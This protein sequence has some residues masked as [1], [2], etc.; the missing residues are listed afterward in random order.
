MFS[1]V[2][3]VFIIQIDSQL[4]PNPNGETAALLRVLLFKIDNTTF[5]NDV[6]PLP[7][8]TGPSRAMVQVQA[9]LFASLTVSLFSAFLA[10]LGKQWLNRYDSTDMRGSAIERSHNRQK[11]LDGIVAWYFN[12]VMES[13]PLMLQAAFLLLGCALSRY[14]WGIDIIIAVVVVGVTSSGV[15]FYL[16]IIIAGMTFESCPYQ[17]P[18]ARIL[19]HIFHHHL[20]ALRSGPS[21]IFAVVSSQCSEFIQTSRCCY[22]FRVWWSLMKPCWSWSNIGYTLAY[23]LLVLPFTL[24]IDGFR[25]GRAILRLLV[26]FGRTVYRGYNATFPPR[27]V[28]SQ[29][30]TSIMSDLRCISWILQTSLDRTIHLSA[31]KRLLSIPKFSHPDPTLV[32][33][34]FGVFIGCINVDNGKAV[35]VQGLEQLAK[36]SASGF[37]RTFHHLIVM[38]P[39]SSILTDLN[40]RYNKVFPTEVDFTGL[41][42]HSTMTMVHTLVNQFGNPRYAWWN[43]RI[44]PGQEHIPF[45]QRMVEAARLKCRQMPHRKVPRWMLRSALHFLSLGSLSPASVVADYLTIIAID[46]SCDL[47]D[48]T[49]LNDRYVCIW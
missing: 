7:Q 38:D 12:H 3:S 17:T 42:F 27:P 4:Q 19:R 22:S 20:P 10:M 18:G 24:A 30:Q 15:L 1:A 46:M 29:E 23:Y 26:A 21:V 45:S 48:T 39:T 47:S 40:R 8:W 32:V 5:G 33:N 37:F 13:L 41:P 25:L 49:S 36:V 44:L 14:L 31:F 43:N 2:T 35:V 16:L 9:I 28:H 11:K 34:C 6:P